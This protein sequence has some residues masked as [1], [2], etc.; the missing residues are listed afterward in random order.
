MPQPIAQL[1]SFQKLNAGAASDKVGEGVLAGQQNID[2]SLEPGAAACRRGSIRF[3]VL[4]SSDP[5]TSMFRNYNDPNSIYNGP[6]YAVG[7][8][9]VIQRARAT[10]TFTSIDTGVVGAIPFGFWE[11]S[12]LIGGGLNHMWRDSGTSLTEWVKQSP[13]DALTPAVSTLT[14]LTVANL[15][16]V[17]EG[18]A[19]TTTNTA[20]AVTDST[21][22]RVVFTATPTSTNLATNG[23]YRIGDYGTDYLDISFSDPSLVSKISRDYSIG[24]TSFD[25]YYHTELQVGFL[26]ESQPDPALLIDAL[27]DSSNVPMTTEQREDMK[28]TLRKLI[29]SPITTISDVPDSFSTWRV[30]RP[31]FNLISS[32]NSNA[33]WSNIGAVRIVVE[34]SGNC[35]VVVK[36]WKIVGAEAF[37]LND[38][39]VGYAWWE[40]FATQDSN[41]F[42]TAESAPSP[43]STRLKCQQAAATIVSTNT[44]TGSLS[45][46]THRILYRQGGYLPDAYAVSSNSIGTYTYTDTTP[47]LVALQNNQVLRRNIYDRLSMPTALTAISE[48]H[49]RRVFVAEGNTLYWS[50]PDQP[51]VFPKTSYTNISQAGDV[52]ALDGLKVWGPLLVVVNR[53]SVYEIEGDVFE[54]ADQNWTLRRSGSRH[55]TKA[56]KV[57]IKTP[58]GIPLLDYDG[59]YLYR[60]GQGVDQPLDW[61]MDQIGDIWKGNGSTNPIALKGTRVPA[62]NKGYINLSFGVWAENKLYLAVPTGSSTSP[63]TIFVLNFQTQQ[64]TG[65]YTYPFNFT[66]GWWDQ[67]DNRLYVGSTVGTIHQLEV[68]L[69]DQDSSASVSGPSWSILTRS[70]SF[71]TEANINNINI[72]LQGTGTIRQ[73]VNGTTTSTVVSTGSIRRQALPNLN[74]TN[75]TLVQ[76]AV[77]GTQGT[78]TQDVVYGLGWSAEIQPARLSYWRSDVQSPQPEGEVEWL[79][80]ENLMDCLGG[81]ATAIV[82]VD[83][84]AISTHSFVGTGPRGYV[85]AL[86]TEKYGRSIYTVYSGGPFKIWKN[87]HD[88]RPEPDR[89]LVHRI[90]DVPFPSDSDLSTLVTQ[91]NPLG[92]TLTAVVRREGVALA[93][94]TLTGSRR[95]TFNVGIDLS[96]ATFTNTFTGNTVDVIYTA[97]GTQPFKH[98]M[99]QIEGVPRPP[100]KLTWRVTYK[101]QGGSSQLDMGRF[102]A[103]DI[104]VP[105]GTATVTSVWEVDGTAVLTNTIEQSASRLWTDR[106]PF[107]PGIRGYLYSQRILSPVPIRVWQT[108]LD[109]QRTGVKGLTRAFYKGEVE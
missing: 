53:D 79:T 63:N 20:T 54:G 24:G 36:D 22:F 60:P 88:S 52:V 95:Q 78:N 12:T 69:F 81:T 73:I 29:R 6:F 45:G 27:S 83:S 103:A 86:P 84:T 66:S 101:K 87:W 74:A 10:S 46:F 8:G 38:P 58:Y 56:G 14:G 42:V 1:E 97:L 33:G 13:S 4:P 7:S 16:G 57:S 96:T 23:G 59:L 70:W 49:Y 85:Q 30:A 39:E 92:G 15:W 108:T 28:D 68:G 55:G 109:V 50:L 91:I 2:L 9:G 89:T 32:S 47:D 11:E 104:E 90:G 80:V 43:I 37:C 5:V 3:S 25:D 35:S 31:N 100:G 17:S 18:T 41:G 62:I 77:N 76:Y 72:D 106:I 34:C 21:T 61:V 48:P 19:V 75:A 82:Y 67:I 105:T 98:Y 40:T 51:D 93:T 99:S 94:A 44:A 71:P 102:W 65:V 107:P 64:V 26:D